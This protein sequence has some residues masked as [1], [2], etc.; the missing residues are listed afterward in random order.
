MAG[1]LCGT[2]SLEVLQCT[3]RQLASLQRTV[4]SPTTR[5]PSATPGTV[6]GLHRRAVVSSSLSSLSKTLTWLSCP[7]QSASKTAQGR[8][9]TLPPP[10][11][12]L[13]NEVMN[14]DFLWS[15]VRGFLQQQH[16]QHSYWS[17][18][19]DPW[20]I[21]TL[22]Q[23]YTLNFWHRL[24]CWL[25][26]TLAFTPLTGTEPGVLTPTVGVVA[27][28]HCGLPD[29]GPYWRGWGGPPGLGRSIV[30]RG[31]QQSQPGCSG[32]W[33]ASDLTNPVHG[34][35]EA[36]SNTVTIS[37]WIVARWAHLIGHPLC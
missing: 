30:D 29:L 7:Q 1:E 37:W 18:R 22:T 3:G 17:C 15:G 14:T 32:T 35:L 9:N 19:L 21:P 2:T 6:H 36:T 31:I 23:R 34:P 16:Q 4:P 24:C 28:P 13:G 11:E 5:V 25:F 12:L 33:L 26:S 10:A 8:P 20:V 27:S